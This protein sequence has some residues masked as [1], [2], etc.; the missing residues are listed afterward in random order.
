MSQ[1]KG[2]D[3]FKVLIRRRFKHNGVREDG[4]VRSA[5][6]R[7][8]GDSC[9]RMNNAIA[10]ALTLNVKVFFEVLVG[11]LGRALGGERDTFVL[12]DSSKLGRECLAVVPH[13]EQAILVEGNDKPRAYYFLFI[14]RRVERGGDSI[15]GIFVRNLISE[16]LLLRP[17]PVRAVAGEVFR[18]A[19]VPLDFPIASTL[20]AKIN[21]SLFKAAVGKR[22]LLVAIARHPDTVQEEAHRITVNEMVDV[23][24]VFFKRTHRRLE[25]R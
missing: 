17:A 16:E 20:K 14:S 13:F 11:I 7:V 21:G 2:G 23:N 12:H 22:S 3:V 4:L 6:P 25:L 10:R 5:V 9:F 19:F 8:L 15:R 24:V 1:R 18:V